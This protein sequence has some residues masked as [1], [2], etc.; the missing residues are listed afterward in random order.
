MRIRATLWA[1]LLVFFSVIILSGCSALDYRSVQDEFNRAVSADN[2]QTIEALGIVTSSGAVRYYADVDRKLD[3][4]YIAQLDDG[5]KPN[6]YALR[7]VSQWRCFK[8]GPARETALTGL[9]LPNIA[10]SPRDRMVLLMIPALV[11][12]EELVSKF[13]AAGRNVNEADYMAM[14]PKDYANAAAMLREAAADISPATPEGIVFYIHMQR[15]RVLQNWRVVISGIDGGRLSGA[16]ARDRAY[17]DAKARLGQDLLN[18]IKGEEQ[19][20][21]PENPIR[22]AMEAIKRH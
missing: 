19:V 15:W 7:A 17:G 14:Y 13:K 2:V 22:R 10:S 12:D 18:E 9:K 20:V 1:A 4:G 5:L 6:A 11:I 16:D 8:L 21:P 3:D